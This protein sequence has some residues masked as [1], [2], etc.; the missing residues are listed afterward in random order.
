VQILKDDNNPENVGKIM[1]WP[2]GVK[3]NAKLQ[4]ELKPEFGKP[5]IPF[6]LFEGKPFLVHVTQVAGFNNYDNSKFLDEKSPL[7]IDG[8]T[9]EKTPESLTK[10]KAFLEQ[11]PELSTYDYQEWDQATEDFVNDVIRNTV[12]GGRMMES[13]EKTNRSTFSTEAPSIK[14]TPVQAPSA[15]AALP[16]LDSPLGTDFDLDMSTGSFDDELYG[17]L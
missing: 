6:D 9:M 17:S 13:I 11:S 15:P 4:A 5:H 14:S 2:Y 12:P 7:V 10:I 8:V 1:A 16:D 3:I